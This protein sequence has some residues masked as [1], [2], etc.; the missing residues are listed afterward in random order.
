MLF[1]RSPLQLAVLNW[2]VALQV[3]HGKP[4]MICVCLLLDAVGCSC[5]KGTLALYIATR[6]FLL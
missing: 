3:D 2:V 1:T 6:Y 4:T 5:I